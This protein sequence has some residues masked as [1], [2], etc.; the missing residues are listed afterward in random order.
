MHIHPVLL[1]G[2]S[3]TRLWPLSR[4]SYPKQFTKLTGDKS[5]FQA[6]A[7]RLS[8]PDY[9]P[10]M[11]VTGSDF[12]FIVTE[13]LQG[14]G[15][16]PGPILLEPEGRNTGPAILAA[17]LHLLATD[18]E[19]VMLIAPSDHVVPD[20]AA[21]G[22]TVRSGLPLAQAGRVVTFGILPD[23]P[24]TGYGTWRWRTSPTGPSPFCISWKSLMPNG[25]PQ[26]WRT[27]A[28]SGTQAFFCAVP[29]RW[30]AHSMTMRPASGLRWQPRCTARRSIWAFCVLQRILGSGRRR[31]RSTMR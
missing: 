7:L 10:P 17:A 1:C 18:S 27:G 28:T 31:C 19:A 13:Q 12:R 11:V 26:C 2:G 14:V 5:L 6:A 20:A 29:T 24:E 25:Q 8:G 16:D 30:F 22:D 4:A 3:G 15:I 23:R 21:F 9:A